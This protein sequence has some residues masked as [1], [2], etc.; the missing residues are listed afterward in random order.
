MSKKPIPIRD[1]RL[2]DAE[3]KQVADKILLL[4]DRDVVEFTEL[5]FTPAKRAAYKA[6]IELFANM[7]TDE[8]LESKKMVA[9]QVKNEKRAIAE[10]IMRRITTMAQLCF[11]AGSS[12]IR[13]FGELALAHQTDDDIVRTARTIELAAT[14]YL[15]D[16]IADGISQ[17]TIQDLQAARERLDLAIDLQNEAI[18]KRDMATSAR[19]SICN[20]LYGFVTKYAEMGK[21]IWR[22]T[23]EAHYNDYVLYD[24]RGAGDEIISAVVV[25]PPLPII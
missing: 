14:L 3:L 12:K 23:S 21:L 13:A 8:L 10:T 20:E 9:T 25:P 7:E 11:K 18:I 17:Q 5:G 1:Y 2:S 16:L 6:Q 24:T 4:I 15:P 22:E 19:V